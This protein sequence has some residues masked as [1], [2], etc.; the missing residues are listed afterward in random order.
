MDPF[1]KIFKGENI[2]AFAKEHNL[3]HNCIRALL[4]DHIKNHKG[5][6]KYSK[7]L[8]GVPFVRREPG[9]VKYFK[10]LDP[11][12]KFFEGENVTAFARDNGLKERGL[13]DVA[14]GNKPSYKGWRKYSKEFEGKP[15][16][17]NDFN[18]SKLFRLLS[19]SGEIVEGKNISQFAK[20]YNLHNKI[21][22]RVINGKQKI[23]RGWRKAPDVS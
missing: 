9:T 1:G 4:R 18:G 21:L 5:W 11:N 2:F 3:D 15:Y 17:P 7:K 8:I 13:A 12:G 14:Y 19:P 22:E 23:H 10:L 16:D 20:K 6:R